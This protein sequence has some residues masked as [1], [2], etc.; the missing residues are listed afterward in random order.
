MCPNRLLTTTLLLLSSPPLLASIR[1]CFAFMGESTLSGFRGCLGTE[2]R[3]TN[4]LFSCIF[5]RWVMSFIPQDRHVGF[6][7]GS[8]RDE[9]I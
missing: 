1:A 4:L 8:L 2:N 7:A 5:I 9:A 3:K 6:H